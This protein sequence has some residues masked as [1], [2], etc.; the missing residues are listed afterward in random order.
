MPI[1]LSLAEALLFAPLVRH[2]LEEGSVHDAIQLVDIHRVDAILQALLLSLM[3]F[4]CF[5]V[6]P[7]LIGVAGM[8]RIAHP[9]QHFVIELQATW[10][11]RELLLQ[12]FLADIF[13]AAR[14]GDKSQA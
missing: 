9:F 1:D 12:L 11:F 8:K 3:T 14:C 4:D 6:F 2:L 7:P 13:A 5:L 10:Q